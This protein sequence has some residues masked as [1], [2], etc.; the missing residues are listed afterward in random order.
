M[1]ILL[2][3]FSFDFVDA[4]CIAAVIG[5][6]CETVD[7]LVLR[8]GDRRGARNNK[9]AIS[10]PERGEREKKQSDAILECEGGEHTRLTGTRSIGVVADRGSSD[11]QA[12]SGSIDKQAQSQ[13]SDLLVTN[14]DLRMVRTHSAPFS[15]TLGGRPSSPK[16]LL[17]K[18]GTPRHGHGRITL[19]KIQPAR[20]PKRLSLIKQPQS[21]PLKHKHPS[22]ASGGENVRDKADA[23]LAGRVAMHW[24]LALV[25]TLELVLSAISDRTQDDE[26]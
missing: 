4:L 10:A 9:V 22:T 1:S 19:S 16:D 24:I 17:Q 23:A 6:L 2:I 25:A 14:N 11:K 7:M 15:P 26:R 8:W 20:S 3:P 18:Y 5:F 12:R 21:W 13:T